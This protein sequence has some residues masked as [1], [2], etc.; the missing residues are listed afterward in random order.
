MPLKNPLPSDGDKKKAVSL[1]HLLNFTVA[2]RDTDAYG[3]T[4]P[5]IRRRSKGIPAFNKEQYLQ[6]KQVMLIAYN[7]FVVYPDKDRELLTWC[8][9]CYYCVV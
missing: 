2:P 1:N 3:Y 9:Q 8:T 7:I 4:L 6:A 5:S